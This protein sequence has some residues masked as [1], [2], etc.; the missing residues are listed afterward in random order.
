MT[1]YEDLV[2]KNARIAAK[3]IHKVVTG[4]LSYAK[5]NRILREMG[6]EEVENLDL[7]QL[8]HK[9]KYNAD[10]MGYDDG[11]GL[12][13]DA[14]LDEGIYETAKDIFRRIHDGKF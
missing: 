1:A 3:N 14:A 10:E 4:E 13:E 11:P 12:G 8:M 2:W 7:L 9:V 5:A 6:M